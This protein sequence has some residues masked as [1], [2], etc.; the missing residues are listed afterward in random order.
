MTDQICTRSVELRADSDTG[1]VEGIAVPWNTRTTIRD[2]MG[3]YEEQ[4]E[5]GSIDVES[6]VRL[7]WQHQDVMGRVLSMEDRDE[8]LWISAQISDTSV[9]RDARA[10]LKDG[11]VDSFSVGFIPK[12]H[13]EE[14]DGLVVRTKV[15]LRE[16]SAVTFPAYT[17][18]TVSSVR[19][20]VPNPATTPQEAPHM[21]DNTATAADLTEVRESVEDLE[22]RMSSF[23]VRSEEPT[24]DT[25]S[26]GEVVKAI[27]SG[28]EDTIKRYNE[29]QARAYTGG[30]IS[31]SVAK[32][33][34]V[35]DLTRIVTEAS[36]LRSAFATGTLP[37]TG[38][39]VE[40]AQL[41][42]DTSAYAV[43]AKEGDPLAFGK[44][45]I[46]TKTAPV[47]TYGGYTTLSRQE[48]ERSSVN[49]LTTALEA[50][51]AAAG[52]ALNAAFRAEY[53]A[54]VAAQK[55]AGNSLVVAA[56]ATY[57]AFLAA[58]VDAAGK[59][60]DLGLALDGIVAG[61][62]T[63]KR[64]L[65]MQGSDGRPVFLVTGQGT[66]NVGAI[67]PKALTG[68]IANVTVVLDP[69]LADGNDAFYNGR[70][71]RDYASPLVRLSDDNVTTLTKDFSVYS[72]D[73]V[74]HEIPAAIVPFGPAS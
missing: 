49:V 35:G 22:R 61:P 46:E 68:D 28:D 29:V 18:A 57:A 71:L 70:A 30:T 9:G 20:D 36:P 25:R 41:K 43:Q 2:W 69:K 16:V 17:A 31:D 24:V 44:V 58:I 15:D 63:F 27:V 8:G 73:A 33:S 21:A 4:F 19:S 26:A 47:K 65:A 59:Y 13:R 55:T 56:N 45:Q 5:R 40:Y 67:N 7:F 51:A 14:E 37:P 60:Q 64:L 62:A 72:Y 34:W 38:M 11:A 3:D 23:V 53:I 6:H 42:S 48:I 74:A 52:K 12:E 32:D 66:N 50:Q 54:E 1:I 10:L 39:N